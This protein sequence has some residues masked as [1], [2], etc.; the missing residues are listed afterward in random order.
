MLRPAER[1]SVQRRVRVDVRRLAH[2]RGEDGHPIQA[3]TGSVV[4]DGRVDVIAR[5]HDPSETAGDADCPATGLRAAGAAPIPCDHWRADDGH[6][7]G[8]VTRDRYPLRTV[9]LLKHKKCPIYR[10]FFS[11]SD[12]TR[13]RDLRRDRPAL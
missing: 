2:H 10:H 4:D 11:G 9:L 8:N 1:H 6:S 12:G 13:T 7:S 5:D 3:V